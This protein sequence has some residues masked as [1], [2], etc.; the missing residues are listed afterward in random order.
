VDRGFLQAPDGT[1]TV[2]N[3]R[4][5]G[6]ASGQGTSPQSINGRAITGYYIDA[7]G[8]NHG[9]LR[10]PGGAITTFDAPGAGTKAGQG[11]FPFQNNNLG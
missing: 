2:F 9:F 5:A 3:V 6:P 7:R 1:V 8:V 4:A 11:T 10:A